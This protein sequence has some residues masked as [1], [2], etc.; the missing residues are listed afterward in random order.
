VTYRGYS[1]EEI[2]EYLPKAEDGPN[3]EGDEPLPESLISLLITGE[4][5]TPHEYEEIMEELKKRRKLSP[6][7]KEYIKRFPKEMHPMTQLSAALLYLEPTSSLKRAVLEH[8]N[9]SN[10]WQYVFE[11]AIDIIAKLPELAAIIYRHKYKNDVFIESNPDL[12]W[13]GNFAHM[14]GFDSF[15]FKEFMR[16]HLTLH[17]YF[18]FHNVVIPMFFFLFE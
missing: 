11:D 12:D 16:G 9:S 14:L 1:I 8:Q 7:V 6:D 4:L 5:P 18:F 2:V 3:G 10:Y 15:E 17:A 13:A